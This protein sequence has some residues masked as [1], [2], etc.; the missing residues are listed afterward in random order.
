MVPVVPNHVCPVVI[1]F[2]ELIV[3]DSAGSLAGALAR[4]RPRI[5]QLIHHRHFTSRTHDPQRSDPT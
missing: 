1:N 2:E 5:P 4:R 3:T